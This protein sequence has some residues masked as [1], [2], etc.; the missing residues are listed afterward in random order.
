M[1]ASRTAKDAQAPSYRRKPVSSLAVHD[2]SLDSG[3]RR[4]DAMRRRAALAIVAFLLSLAAPRIAIAQAS[5]EGLLLAAA[6]ASD[7][8]ERSRECPEHKESESRA[9]VLANHAASLPCQLP[10]PAPEPEDHGECIEAFDHSVSNDIQLAF[11]ANDS[12]AL[13]PRAPPLPDLNMDPP[14]PWPS[15]ERT[16][17]GQ[18]IAGYAGARAPPSL[19]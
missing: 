4:N 19:V 2:S 5:A 8:R 10:A 11:P 14:A 3:F 13:T 6:G 15:H 9:L 18:A 17:I 12:A 16:E 7:S 1:Y